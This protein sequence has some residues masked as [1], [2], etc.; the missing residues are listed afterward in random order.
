MGKKR[1]GAH[2]SRPAAPQAAS[3]A[4]P[5]CKS[6]L[7]GGARSLVRLIGGGSGVLGLVQPRVEFCSLARIAHLVV[8]GVEVLR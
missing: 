5:V 7:A 2:A 3:V 4:P 8:G 6:L 1:A